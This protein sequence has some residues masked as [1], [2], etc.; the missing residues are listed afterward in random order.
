[1]SNPFRSLQYLPWSVLAQSAA[2]TI[3]IAT[4]LDY[5]A[6]WGITRWMHT[7]P[8]SALQIVI[9]TLFFATLA[10][11]YGIGALALILTERFFREVVLT[12]ETIWALIGCVIL[13]YLLRTWLPVPGVLMLVNLYNVV[14]ISLGAF[15][16][17]KRYWR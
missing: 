16:T 12:A 7:Q 15:F 1:M 6:Y 4:V 14:L 8:E 17:G 2:V 13:F 11:A 3:A 9:S 10:A 5:G